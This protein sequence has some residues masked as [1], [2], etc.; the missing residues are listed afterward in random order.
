[1]SESICTKISPILGPFCGSAS[2]DFSFIIV[3]LVISKQKIILIKLTFLYLHIY[4]VAEKS[5]YNCKYVRQNLFLYYLL[6][7]VL[8]SIQTTVRF[9]RPVF[10]ESYLLN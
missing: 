4:R 3:D 8:F 10:P 5:V 9:P 6:I 1:M 7:I 2:F